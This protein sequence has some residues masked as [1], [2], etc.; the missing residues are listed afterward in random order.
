MAAV[1]NHGKF[2]GAV[3]RTAEFFPTLQSYL[4]KFIKLAK[5]G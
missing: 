2:L 1:V 4:N 3:K 5:K